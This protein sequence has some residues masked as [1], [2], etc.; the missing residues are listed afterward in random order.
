MVGDATG[1]HCGLPVEMTV[2]NTKPQS[3]NISI[4]Y[5]RAPVK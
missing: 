3:H 1:F 2:K 4:L 5:V